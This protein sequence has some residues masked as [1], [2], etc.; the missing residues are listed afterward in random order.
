MLPNTFEY[1]FI[2]Y[3][4]LRLRRDPRRLAPATV[5]SA[6]AAIWIVVKLPQ[7]YWLHIARLDLT[8]V[9]KTALF[10]ASPQTPWGHI[11]RA[12]PWLYAGVALLAVGVLLALAWLATRRLPPPDDGRQAT[13]PGQPADSPRRP[14]SVLGGPSSTVTRAQLHAARA[15]WAA[16]IF[17]R[18]LGEKLALVALITAIFAHILPGVRPATPLVVLGATA[19]VVLTT[20]LSHLVARRGVTWTNT[21]GQFLAILGAN[22][23]AVFLFQALPGARDLNEAEVLAFVLLLSVIVTLFDRF[24]IYQRARWAEERG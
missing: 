19:V 6:A 7:E 23:T 20:A 13:A 3:E 14:W 11:F 1:Y 22:F 21:L 17:D 18:D 5:V 4:L 12:A 24:Q 15:E 16:Q 2:W 10:G 8:D 9:L